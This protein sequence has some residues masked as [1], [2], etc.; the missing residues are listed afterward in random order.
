MGLFAASSSIARALLLHDDEKHHKGEKQHQNYKKT[1]YRVVHAAL[2]HN[3]SHC[4]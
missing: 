2:S 4:G 1:Y 3:T